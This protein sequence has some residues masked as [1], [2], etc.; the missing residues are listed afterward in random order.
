MTK[1]HVSKDFVIC[2][3]EGIIENSQFFIEAN[4]NIERHKEKTKTLTELKEHFQT[5]FKR[6]EKKGL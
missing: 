4:R 6:L 1:G 5:I 2:V 3:I